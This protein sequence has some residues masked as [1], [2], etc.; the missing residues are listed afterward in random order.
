MPGGPTPAVRPVC[1]KPA[2]AKG[3]REDEQRSE[4]YSQA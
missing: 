1:S 2:P 4:G 3:V